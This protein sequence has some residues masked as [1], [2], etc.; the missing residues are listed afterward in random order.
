MKIKY[1]EKSIFD[2]SSMYILTGKIN[3]QILKI[4]KQAVWVINHSDTKNFAKIRFFVFR[5]EWF[6]FIKK[7]CVNSSRFLV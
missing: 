5:D 2:V 6:T 3:P 4:P 7:P 1:K